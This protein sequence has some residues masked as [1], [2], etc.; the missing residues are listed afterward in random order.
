MVQEM[1]IVIN[2]PDIY[3]SFVLEWK[4]KWAP[5]ILIYARKLKKKDISAIIKEY[6]DKEGIIL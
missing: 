4:E 2:R 3:K 6:D 5:A 1:E